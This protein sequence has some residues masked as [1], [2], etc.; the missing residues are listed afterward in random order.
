MFNLKRQNQTPN[1]ELGLDRQRGNYKFN[2]F[3]GMNGR[4][5]VEAEYRPRI[6][7]SDSDGEEEIT[8]TRRNDRRPWRYE[9]YDENRYGDYKPKIGIRNFDGHLHIE[10]YLDWKQSVDNF[11]SYM[12]IR[13]E[14]QVQF[15]A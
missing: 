4:S 6:H 15:V 11:F 2:S 9:R 5:D 10:D 12:E 7:S 3:M 1:R 13:V 14:K 8:S